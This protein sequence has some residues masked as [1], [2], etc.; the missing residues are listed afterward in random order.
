MGSP[1]A[2]LGDMHVCPDV[3]KSTPPVPHVGGPI[4]VGCTSV[5]I[6]GMPAAVKGNKCVCVGP[7]SSINEGSSGVK[8]EG[9]PAARLGDGCTHGGKIVAGCVTVLIGD[10]KS[11]S[12]SQAK[13]SSGS[14]QG[15][16]S[17]NSKASTNAQESALREGAE[18]GAPFVEV[19]PFQGK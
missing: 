14:S 8:I 2:R 16:D 3:V 18:K 1:A 15:K 7:P 5:F 11:S 6:G 19:C 9:K 12:V 13:S 4:I 10:K 17:Q